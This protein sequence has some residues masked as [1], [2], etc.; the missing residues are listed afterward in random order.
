MNYDRSPPGSAEAKVTPTVKCVLEL[1]DPDGT[2]VYT[3][4]KISCQYAEDPDSIFV[5]NV[6]LPT[7]VFQTVPSE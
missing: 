4:T 5:H 7:P 6:P 2:L 3:P 1:V